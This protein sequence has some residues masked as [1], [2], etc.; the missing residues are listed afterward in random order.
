MLVFRRESGAFIETKTRYSEYHLH[1]T[2]FFVQINRQI[3]N[4]LTNY[5]ISF[6]PICKKRESSVIRKSRDLIYGLIYDHG[7]HWKPL[8]RLKWQKEENQTTI[9]PI[10]KISASCVLSILRRGFDGELELSK[11]LSVVTCYKR[12]ISSG[13]MI[14]WPCL[15][16][17]VVQVNFNTRSCRCQNPIVSTRFANS[18]YTA[19]HHAS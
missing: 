8:E 13:C 19:T 14:I 11:H 2:T 9:G 15:S 7:N 1:T 10:Y 18:L 6:W 17:L 5:L 3:T 16:A 4:Q 12:N